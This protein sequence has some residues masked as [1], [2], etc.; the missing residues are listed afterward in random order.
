MTTETQSYTDTAQASTDG[1]QRDVGP[2]FLANFVHQVVNPLNGVIGTLDNISDK[3]Y[4]GPVA[5]QKINACRA[6]LEQCVTLIRNLAYLSDYFFEASGKDALRKAR[7]SG[8]S[9][10]PQVIIEALQF[11]QIAADKKHLKI[12]LLDSKNQYRIAVRPELLKQVFINLFDNWLKY[13]LHD[14]TVSITTS[15]NRKKELVVEVT[16]NSIGF[17]NHDAERIFELGFR[18]KE[19]EGRVAQGSGIGLYI[20]RQ[21]VE[22]TLGGSI[23]ATHQPRTSKTT[24]RISIPKEKWQL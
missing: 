22:L 5:D 9:V 4:K 13:G 23:S 7:E 19:A 20:C 16:G 3:T 24:F 1:S 6:Q 18:S 2:L 10:L 14:Q 17:S 8:T 12:E 15:V 11:F 21:I